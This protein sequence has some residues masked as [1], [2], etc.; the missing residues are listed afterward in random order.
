MALEMIAAVREV[1]NSLATIAES[2]EKAIESVKR[3]AGSISDGLKSRRL[4][5][6][7]DALSN[8]YFTPVGVQMEIESYIKNPSRDNLRSLEERLEQNQNMISD[9]SR[10]LYQDMDSNLF[11]LPLSS[12]DY[13]FGIK[14]KLHL[15]IYNAQWDLE[16][17]SAEERQSYLTETKNTFD[18]FNRKLEKVIRNIKEITG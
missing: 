4:R 8:F 14:S 7:G 10:I 18:D 6:I 9:V 11:D 13:I 3:S 17:M 1:L 5:K 16:R 2:V 12:I 15:A